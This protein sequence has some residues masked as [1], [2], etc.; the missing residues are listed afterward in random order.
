[1]N[2]RCAI[3]KAALWLGILWVRL[4]RKLYPSNS[5][6]REVISDALGDLDYATFSY[7]SKATKAKSKP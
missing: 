7:Y 4:V 5:Y 2:V 3:A 1:M 6:G